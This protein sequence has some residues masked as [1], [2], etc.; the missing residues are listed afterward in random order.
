MPD[1][2][3]C[4]FVHTLNHTRGG[5]TLTPVN[6][7]DRAPASATNWHADCHSASAPAVDNP[8]GVTPAADDR[9]R[10]VLADGRSLG[11]AEF[12]DRDGS[13]VVDCHGFPGS[14]LE[15]RLTDAAALGLGLRIV[16]PDRP[17]YGRSDYQPHRCLADWPRDVVALADALGSSRFAVLG[18]SGEGPYALACAGRLQARVSRVGIIC[19]LG[20]LHAVGQIRGMSP[21]AAVVLAMAR[22][23]PRLTRGPFQGLAGWLLGRRP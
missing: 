10:V 19:A 4:C 11:Y 8:S 13:P 15:A 17:G 2:Q 3:S 7:F 12:G 6:H 1:T 20:E 14:R 18:V 9:G 5:N 23:I 22:R 16:A 21:V